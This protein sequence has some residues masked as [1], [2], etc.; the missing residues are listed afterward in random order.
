MSK[1]QPNR[2]QREI[3]TVRKMI[4][5]YC[6]AH[7]AP[8]D[9]DLCPDCQALAD[10]AAQRVARCPFGAEKPNC[11][12]CPVHCYAPKQREEIRRVMRYAGPRM[13]LHHPIL[14]ILHLLDS[15]RKPR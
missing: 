8:Q 7:H 9:G 11:D 15:L 6:R 2:L 13:I 12:K 1:V 10:Y 5:L 4:V 3:D 14:A